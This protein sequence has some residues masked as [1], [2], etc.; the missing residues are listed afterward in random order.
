[1]TH[2]PYR[3]PPGPLRRGE[4]FRNG[5]PVLLN[6]YCK[7]LLILTILRGVEFVGINLKKNGFRY[8]CTQETGKCLSFVR[9]LRQP[10]CGNSGFFGGTGN[11]YSYFVKSIN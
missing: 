4:K 5:G 1:M 7:F 8:K 6:K 10:E 3:P 9:V 11:L 2:R